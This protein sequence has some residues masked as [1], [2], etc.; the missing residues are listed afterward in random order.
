MR[1]C[2]R[3]LYEHRLVIRIAS[4]ESEKA[5]DG[6]SEIDLGAHQP[7]RP[8]IIDYEATSEDRDDSVIVGASD[9]NDG[10]AWMSLKVENRGRGHRRSCRR[11]IDAE[12]IAATCSSDIA[13]GMIK[14]FE[15]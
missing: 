14:Q 2:V 12:H 9:E 5:N 7:V 15:E 11:S 10:A 6:C 1:E 4:A 8:L 3:V 13:I